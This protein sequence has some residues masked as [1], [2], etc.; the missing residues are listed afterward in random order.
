[1]ALVETDVDDAPEEDEVAFRKFKGLELGAKQ[2]AVLGQEVLEEVG[3]NCAPVSNRR[4]FSD[5]FQTFVKN[6]YS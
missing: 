2:I 5:N 3:I 1:L 4:Y 6:G